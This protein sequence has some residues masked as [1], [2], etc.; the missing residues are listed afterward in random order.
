MYNE[1]SMRQKTRVPSL[2]VY[3]C[4]HICTPTVHF[5]WVLTVTR[6]LNSHST[7]QSPSYKHTH[8]PLA[9]R[10]KN[11]T[12][13]NK[14]PRF[15]LQFQ[16]VSGALTLTHRHFLAETVR[17]QGHS[18]LLFWC[19][20]TLMVSKGEQ[21][22]LGMFFTGH[23]SSPPAVTHSVDTFRVSKGGYDVAEDCRQTASGALKSSGQ[24]FSFQ[25]LVRTN[26]PFSTY[27]RLK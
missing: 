24:Q 15:N 1:S 22:L 4:K 23:F 25:L 20:F 11:S 8:L 6:T 5:L 3:V 10:L 9:S 18:S 12:S 7:L 21:E 27:F 16:T 14:G 17:K 2:P 13:A 26:N 19:N